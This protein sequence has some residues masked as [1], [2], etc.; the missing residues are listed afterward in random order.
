MG[1]QDGQRGES[2][3]VC[4]CVRACVCERECVC[5]CVCVCMCICVYMHMHVCMYVCMYLFIYVC[6]YFCAY[7]RL[8]VS[9]QLSHSQP[10]IFYSICLFH[11]LMF[12]S[13]V[14]QS[15]LS[16]T[17][18]LFPVFSSYLLP[19]FLLSITR[20]FPFISPLYSSFLN[21]FFLN[22]SSLL[23]YIF[24]RYVGGKSGH[25]CG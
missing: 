16:T 5:I 6:I 14:D 22:P 17:T 23:F 7:V 21:P 4:V 13:K 9:T 2:W 12:L 24:I 19:F 20:P 18:S 3:N 15:T 11:T 8:Y 1:H 10:L 25:H